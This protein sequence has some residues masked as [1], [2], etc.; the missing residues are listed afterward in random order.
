MNFSNCPAN[1]FH[2]LEMSILILISLIKCKVFGLVAWMNTIKTT[3]IYL[4]Q[5][6][7][8]HLWKS[9][10]MPFFSQSYKFMQWKISFLIFFSSYVTTTC[11]Y[12]PQTI[13]DPLNP[14]G[15]PQGVPQFQLQHIKLNT[16]SYIAILILFTYMMVNGV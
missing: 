11:P 15:H 13:V 6:F 1:L 12:L 3:F 9:F 4:A 7:F 5:K 14:W 8:F 2:P 10:N 16:P